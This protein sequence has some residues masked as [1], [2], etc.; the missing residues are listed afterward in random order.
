VLCDFRPRVQQIADL[1]G[2]LIEIGAESVQLAAA[3]KGDGHLELSVT[4][5]GYHRRHHPQPSHELAGEEKANA[6][7]KEECQER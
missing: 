5:G 1:L 7:A 3:P 4:P 6:R 2:H